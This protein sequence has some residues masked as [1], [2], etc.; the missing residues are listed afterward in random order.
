MIFRGTSLFYLQQPQTHSFNFPWY[1]V[2]Y[3]AQSNSRALHRQLSKLEG[4][5]PDDQ[6]DYPSDAQ[7]FST[8]VR[9]GDIIV[10]FV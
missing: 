9:G 7:E 1:V 2:E 4:G 10:A 3:Y 6:A 5:H 8:T